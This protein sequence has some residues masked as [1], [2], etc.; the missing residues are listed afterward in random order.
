[1]ASPRKLFS[2]EGIGAKYATFKIDDSTI[3]YDVDEAGGSAEVGFAVGLSADET[4]QLVSDAEGVLGKLIKVEEDDTCTVQVRGYMTLPGGTSATLTLGSA[5][6]GDLLVAAKGYIRVVDTAAAAELGVCRGTIV[7]AGTSTA[8][9][10]L[11]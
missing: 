6:V 8:V 11:L 7:D 10:V 9:W 5:V 3:T 2:W 4:V 1:M